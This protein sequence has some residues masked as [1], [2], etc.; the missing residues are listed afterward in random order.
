MK[1]M[2]VVA[3]TGDS[4]ISIIDPLKLDEVQR[5]KLLD[6]SGPYDL[7][8]CN[9][10]PYIFV[11]QYFA[12]SLSCIDLLKGKVLDSIMV[13]RRPCHIAYDRK[14][15][16]IFTTNSDSDTVSIVRGIE[17]SLIGQIRVGSMPQGIDFDSV[18]NSLAIANA[19]SRDVMIVDGDDFSIKQIIKLDQNPF[20][21][22]FSANGKSLFTS[23]FHS[24][25]GD[26]GS[27]LVIDTYTNRVSREIPL[28]SIPGQLYNTKDGQ[29]LL[30]ASMGKGGLEIFDINRKNPSI[31]V[32]TNEMTHGMAM[33]PRERYVYVTNPH[34]NSIS[35]VDWKL[36][37]K[38]A[39]IGVGI[40]PNGI[41]YIN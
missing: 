27:V 9:S 16:I 31:K 21:V 6:N 34:D 22:Q 30:I 38:I 5:I 11:S 7:V 26:S 3:N 4:S 39:T 33:D 8:S 23:C 41:L 35:A 37:K 10:G 36:G 25:N 2:I 17:M 19:D 40:E 12:D 14:R 18:S 15:D 29:Y 32:S 24:H 1:S 20:Y 28:E 13:G